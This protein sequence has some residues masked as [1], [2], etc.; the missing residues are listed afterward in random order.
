MNFRRFSC[1]CLALVLAGA[2]AVTGAV[3]QDSSGAP[4]QRGGQG[5]PGGRGMGMGRGVLGTVSD[6]ASDHLTIKNEAG[7]VY[8]VYFS[9]NTRFMKTVPR[10]AGAAADNQQGGGR[11]DPPVAIKATDIKAG[12]A[13]MAGGEVD[14]TKKTVGAVSIVQLDPERA[15]QMREMQANFGKTWLMGRV[16]AVNET[17][18]TIESDVDKASHVFA[19][20]ENTTFRKRRD[21]VTLAD[22]QVGDMVRVEGAV[23]GGVFM[24]TSVM[25]AG[26]PGGQRPAGAGPGGGPGTAPVQPQ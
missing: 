3:A 9:A 24:A 14:D 5:G 8:T 20:D 25:V 16:T 26:Q 15:K 1:F 22:V 23:K 17:K 19:A 7:A 4:P 12:D 13:V 6:V 21:P 18:V 10:A 2:F 11:M